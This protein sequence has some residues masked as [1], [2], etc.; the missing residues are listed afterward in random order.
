MRDPGFQTG[1]STAPSVLSRNQHEM[2]AVKD[3]ALVLLHTKI[4]F[5][6]DIYPS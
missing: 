1:N 6:F 5:R 3:G 4:E 2:S